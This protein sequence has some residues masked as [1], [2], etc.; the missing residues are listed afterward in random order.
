M[1]KT[2]LTDISDETDLKIE[3]MKHL[4]KIE[5]VFIKTSTKLG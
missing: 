5:K 2:I 1:E 4:K 3:F